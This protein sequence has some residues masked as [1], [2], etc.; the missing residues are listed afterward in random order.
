M[1][2]RIFLLCTA[3]LM[4]AAC[5]DTT[6]MYDTLGYGEKTDNSI[7]F[8]NYVGGMT[9]ASRGTG[10]TFLTGDKIEV[11]GFMTTGTIVDKLF[12][13]QSVEKKDD[14]TW[15]YSPKKYWNIGSEYDFYAIFPYSDGNSFDDAGKTFSVTDFVV[16]ENTANQV[17]LMIAQQILNASAPNTVNFVFNHILS[18]VSF[19]VKTSDDFVTTG[20]D[21]IEVVSFDVKG[22][23]KKGSF[24]Q[25]G[26][27][28]ENAFEGSWTADANVVYNL[29]QV[30][31][32][33]YNIGA[34]QASA[35]T[36]DQ[37]LLPQT[38]SDNAVITI[39]YTVFYDD[40][41]S[42]TFTKSVKLN[43]IVGSNGI[44]SSI[45]AAWNPNY[46]Y[47]YIIAVN[48]SM[49][50]IKPI[51]KDDNDQNDYEDPNADTTPNVNIIEIDT[52]G[53]GV[54]DEYW[55]DEDGDGN[56]DYPII[57]EDIDGDGKEEAIPD[58]DGDGIPDDSDGDGS[59]DVIWVDT[60]GDGIVDTELE[61]EVE[62][63]PG[64]ITD[65]DDPNYPDEPN[66][67]FNGG[68]DNYL[69]PSGYLITD[70]E[71]EYWIDLDGDGVGDIE[72]L[73]KDIDGDGKLEG[74]ADKNGDGIL[75]IEDSY[76]NDGLDYNGN[77]N[78]YD[79]IMIDTNGDG[80]ADTEL[81]KDIT[82]VPDDL[83][84]DEVEESAIEFS[85]EVGSWVD[86]YDAPYKM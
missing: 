35:I 17:D 50:K 36:Q 40:T 11:Y 27:N 66:A 3:A 73:W 2:P 52:D 45:L 70:N 4:V 60:D 76:D 16:E 23:Y 51:A 41:T 26:W 22:L 79:V 49:T 31:G 61:R 78:D 32:V 15:T 14:G 9:R 77:P 30:T 43:K 42:S 6:L 62:V 21:R 71:G 7:E 28:N 68:V 75:T 39:T 80:I 13:K 10:N 37:L 38:I 5:Q 59:P 55:I 33:V 12:N 57:W 44:Q 20:I 29:P 58:R 83:P 46:R 85:A 74:I 72:I 53:D 82:V 47:N 65:P 67:D 56:P 63:G 1:K 81:E 19:Y 8:G 64:V 54:T 24:A 34:A 86:E 48:P 84:D 69:E 25:T 18:N